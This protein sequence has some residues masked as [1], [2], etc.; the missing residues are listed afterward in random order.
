MPVVARIVSRE[1]DDC[2]DR[3]RRGRFGCGLDDALTQRNNVRDRCVWRVLARVLLEG[4]D[5][6]RASLWL[7]PPV[8]AHKK[9]RYSYVYQQPLLRCALDIATLASQERRKVACQ[10]SERNLPWC[11]GCATTGIFSFSAGKLSHWRGTIKPDKLFKN[12]PGIAPPRRNPTAPL[13]L[14]RPPLAHSQPRS[15]PNS[16]SPHYAGPEALSRELLQTGENPHPHSSTDGPPGIFLLS[17]EGGSSSVVCRR[18]GREEPRRIG[19]VSGAVL[20]GTR[21][22]AG[23]EGRRTGCC[24]GGEGGRGGGE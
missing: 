18:S 20:R 8:V 10:I 3:R 16:G 21:V 2:V 22:Q 13:I 5:G 4:I 6:K 7:T 19:G 11:V 23:G 15:L 14:P 17:G 24:G 1:I 9:R 12:S